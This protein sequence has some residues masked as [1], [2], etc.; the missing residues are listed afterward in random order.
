MQGHTPAFAP[1]TGT[2]RRVRGAG[3]EHVAPKWRFDGGA[4]ATIE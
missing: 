1:F 4:T 3:A 2:I